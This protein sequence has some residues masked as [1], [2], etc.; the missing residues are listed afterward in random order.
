MSHIALT[1]GD[2]FLGWHARCAALA[3]GNA[4]I[5]IDV[6][7]GFTP[8]TARDA[9]DGS[10]RFLHIAGVN[11]GTDEE[12]LEGNLLFARQIADVL[13]SVDSPPPVVVFANST[14]VGNGSVY[15]K[16]KEEAA[17]ILA[18]AAS[19][20]GAEFIDIHLPNLFGEHGRPF[21]NSVVSTFCHLLATGGTPT[22]DRDKDMTLLH[23]QDAADVLL[24]EAVLDDDLTEHATVTG[25]LSTLTDIS[26]VYATGEIPSLESVFVRNLFNTYR[27]F[28]FEHR[29]A[30]ALEPHADDR[31]FLVEMVRSHGGQGQ[32]VLS[33]TKPGASRADHF[34]RR[35]FERI[36]LLH[37][38]GVVS[39]R[40]LL[41]TKAIDI[42]V[43]GS[44][45]IAIDVPTLWT[46]RVDNTGTDDLHL[47]YWVNR[48]FDPSDPDTFAEI[49]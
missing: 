21:Y 38:Q 16:A 15:A 28:V 31:G 17:G 19:H 42:E 10:S 29:T 6:G 1:G 30:I 8:S 34:H 25:L 33:T 22:I 20:V 45:P 26:R 40:R 14:Q 32:V 18:A 9:I 3:S 46:H 27:S 36:T 7:E 23:A 24:G 39:L 35:K 41:S 48:L 47:C 2:G 49:P 4:S 5:H 13:G 11:R 12:V 44:N 43:S 37:G